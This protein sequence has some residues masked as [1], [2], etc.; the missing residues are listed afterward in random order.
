M[1][2]DRAWPQIEA[3]GTG[4]SPQDVPTAGIR[5]AIY[6]HDTMGLGHKRRNVLIAQQL[7]QSIPH[8]SVLL[9]TGMIEAN[10]VDLPPGI[11]YLALPAWHK[12]PEGHYRSRRLALSCA[13]LTRLRGNLIRTAVEAFKPDL[14]LVDNVPR[15]ALGELDGVLDHVRRRP[16]T[17]CVLGLRD[18]LDEPAV[19]RRQWRQAN[20]EQ[21]LRRYFD[22]VWIYG[23]PTVY[24]LVK[25]Y[26]LPADIAA[27]VRY[28]GYLDPRQRLSVAAPGVPS[29]PDER[30][31]ALCLVGGGQDGAAV[32]LAF[33]QATLPSGWRGIVVAGPLM[34]SGDRQEL[35]QQAAHRSDLMVLDDYSEPTQLVRQAQAVISMGGYN[36][37]CEVL[38]FETRTLIIPRVKPRREQ[39]LRAKRLQ[40][41]GLVDMLH[42]D[43]ISPMVLSQWL[44]GSD[45]PQ[46]RVRRRDPIDLGG[47]DRLPQLVTGL[48]NTSPHHPAV[49]LAAV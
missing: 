49:Q 35:H 40:A 14:F 37:T 41:L 36:T 43:Q 17:R 46:A 4:G 5:V 39:W 24:D 1:V 29:T 48:L 33:S 6:S 21:A 27:K 16:Q 47:L 20:N 42:P 12:T 18:I 34:P 10:A 9:I 45:A 15:G 13:E 31:L 7:V 26:R 19:V 25:A 3:V 28:V 30:P 44:A 8:C 38:A 11:D 32:A 23:D 22:A 2:N